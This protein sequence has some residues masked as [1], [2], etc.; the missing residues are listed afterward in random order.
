ML[1]KACGVV[2][3]YMYDG[4]PGGGPTVGVGLG[5]IVFVG[6]AVGEPTVGVLV[7]VL[8]GPVTQEGN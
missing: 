8:V 3:S 6:V 4:H 2:P 5:V 1:P 7:K